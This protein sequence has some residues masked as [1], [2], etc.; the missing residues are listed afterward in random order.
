MGGKNQN[1]ESSSDSNS[2]ELEE[3][4]ESQKNVA[5]VNR[6][7][8][9]RK[10]AADIAEELRLEQ[11][12]QDEDSIAE[13][14][15]KVHETLNPA[16]FMNL[17]LETFCISLNN[18]RVITVTRKQSTDVC[19]MQVKFC[20]SGNIRWNRLYEIALAVL[21]F[22][23]GF[24]QCGLIAVH[25]KQ[26]GTRTEILDEDCYTNKTKPK[27][28][29]IVLSC[30]PGEYIRT[31]N[32]GGSPFVRLTAFKLQET[33]RSKGHG[34]ALLSILRFL[35]C[36][37]TQPLKITDALE[38]GKAERLSWKRN[39]YFFQGDK[40][41]SPPKYSEAS[42]SDAGPAF[43]LCDLQ[44]VFADDVMKKNGFFDK[45]GLK[46]TLLRGLVWECKEMLSTAAQPSNEDDS[47]E[48]SSDSEDISI[49]EVFSK[50]VEVRMNPERRVDTDG[51]SESRFQEKLSLEQDT[52]EVKCF[53][54]DLK[55]LRLNRQEREVKQNQEQKHF[56][57]GRPLL[58]GENEDLDEEGAGEDLG[59]QD[60]EDG[61]PPPLN[62]P[63]SSLPLMFFAFFCR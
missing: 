6:K 27:L 10:T 56:E 36:K 22:D 18:E 38:N 15:C 48:S 13:S 42:W 53:L 34:S 46:A 17:S 49:S 24:W 12:K 33:H 63:M 3:G 50:Q 29:G 5:L 14:K 39:G 20:A 21:C 8:K 60:T 41:N 2:D 9:K 16:E 58:G 1:Q 31:S 62:S 47:T 32:C 52:E 4:G 26:D 25:V 37:H 35:C 51:D 40:D 59:S 43:L 28:E 54:G 55:N 44:Q 30:L 61:V 7:A 45:M 19:R 57:D 11:Q 23:D